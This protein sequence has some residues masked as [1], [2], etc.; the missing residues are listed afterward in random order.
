MNTSQAAQEIKLIAGKFKGIIALAEALEKIGSI[1]NSEKEARGRVVKAQKEEAEAR[2][3]VKAVQ[4]DLKGALDSIQEARVKALERI[5]NAKVDASDIIA[6]AQV[7]AMEIVEAAED[8]RDEM[9]RQVKESNKKL[10]KIQADVHAKELE[11][12]T[13]QKQIDAAHSKI[14]AFVKPSERMD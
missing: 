3:K 6:K 1:E 5:E 2:E 12:E 7:T 10:E 8:H 14:S 4:A 13:V 11:L 9:S